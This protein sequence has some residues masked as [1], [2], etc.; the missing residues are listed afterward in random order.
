[1]VATSLRSL[2]LGRQSFEKSVHPNNFSHKVYNVELLV[3]HFHPLFFHQLALWFLP[4][5]IAQTAQ[6]GTQPLT[7]I[8]G[9]SFC[10][11]RCCAFFSEN[12]IYQMVIKQLIQLKY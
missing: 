11:K 3:Q 8:Q 1:M 10:H 12:S 7:E 6:F 4:T 5:D 2:I 9:Q